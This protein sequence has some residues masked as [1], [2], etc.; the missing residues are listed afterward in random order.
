MYRT[1]IVPL[2]RSSETEAAIQ[3]AATLAQQAEAQLELLTVTTSDGDTNT[4]HDYL[5]DTAE[6]HGVKANLTTTHTDDTTATILEAASHPD[7]LLC[8]RTHARGPIGEI[9]LGSVSQDIVRHN[10]HPLVLV[11]PNC[12][13]APERY[14]SLIVALDGSPLAEKVLPIAADWSAHLHLT[15]W[16]FQVLPAPTPLE[17]GSTDIYETNYVHRHAQEL[18]RQGVPTEWET[19]RDRNPHAAI[20]RF[21]QTRPNA[22][23]ALTTHGRSGLSRL[24]LGS[25]ALQTA[26]HATVPVLTYRPP[27]D[28][29]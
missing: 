25:I 21:A 18:A 8:M 9:A 2:D 14:S 10:P 5:S 7:T 11:G 26:H 27:Q 28:D 19:A 15:P 3:H 13:P 12:G 22:L 6:R 17:S 4:A 23:I 1:V 16:L 29:A 20:C 24:A